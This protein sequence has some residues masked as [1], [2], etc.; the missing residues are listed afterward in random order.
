MAE[1]SSTDVHSA[2]RASATLR[3]LLDPATAIP[4]GSIPLTSAAS[5]IPPGSTAPAAASIPSTATSSGTGGLYIYL[6]VKPFEEH[7]VDNLFG[8]P[9]HR[10]RDFTDQLAGLGAR[11][12]LL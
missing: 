10:W 12:T 7:T 1:S 11:N 8:H 3:A 4:V 6:A 5:A 2:E 9:P